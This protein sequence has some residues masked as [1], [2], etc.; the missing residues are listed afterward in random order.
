MDINDMIK[1]ILIL[2]T[3]MHS[4][5]YARVINSEIKCQITAFNEDRV[6]LFCPPNSKNKVILPRSKLE[7][8][9]LKPDIIIS[10]QSTKKEISNILKGKKR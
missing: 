6:S 1:T 9:D 8:Y 2:S 10:Y 7:N 5:S 3:L 4:L